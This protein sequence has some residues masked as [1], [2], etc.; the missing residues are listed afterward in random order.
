MN[1]GDI[2]KKIAFI[3]LIFGSVLIFIF[4]R[5]LYSKESSNSV[6]QLD[7]STQQTEE[8]KVVT[9]N[10]TQQGTI[11]ADQTVE[12]TFNTPLENGDEVKH[13]LE[14]TTDYKIKLSDD[15]KTAQFIPQKP[16]TLGTTYTIFIQP[17]TKFAG[18]KLF[19]KEFI[20]NFRTIEYRGV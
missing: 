12:I 10:P 8:I 13:K 14:P 5:G 11:M 9:T 1:I 19:N 4:Q 17:E 20:F 18:K 16:W 3:V 7:S 15:R 6:K 2:K